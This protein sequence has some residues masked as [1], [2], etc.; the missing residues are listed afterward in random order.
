METLKNVSVFK[1]GKEL[2]TF[3]CTRCEIT[4][5]DVRF[6]GVPQKTGGNLT[7]FYNGGIWYDVDFINRTAIVKPETEPG[8][9]IVVIW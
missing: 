1:N 6:H 7:L 4:G 9:E 2:K 5:R 8:I 3:E